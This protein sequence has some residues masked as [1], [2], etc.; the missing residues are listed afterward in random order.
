MRVLILGGTRNLGHDLVLHLLASGHAVSVLN[1]GRT[2]DTLPATVDR[3]RADRS[4]PGELREA[5]GRRRW[6]VVVD[7]TLYNGPDAE[8]AIELFSGRVE[9]YLFISTGQVYLVRT[10]APRPARE[11]DYAGPVLAEPV[12]GSRDH[13]NWV[14]GVEKRAAEDA[15]A[16]AGKESEF[17]VTALRLPMVNSRRDHYGRLHGYILR[18]QDGG[19]ILVPDGPGLSLRH[20]YGDDV[21]RVIGLLLESGTGKGEAFNLAQDE[22]V[23]LEEFLG[24]VSQAIPG[25][26]GR[27]RLTRAPLARL[28]E[29]HLFP[30]CSPFSD[31]WMSALDNRK[32]KAALGF[33]Y[34][35]LAVYLPQLVRHYLDTRPAAPAGYEQRPQELEL[36]EAGRP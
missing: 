8:A 26:R 23:S 11:E 16:R 30:A 15:L 5:V 31:T 4:A 12:A 14:Y 3:L 33:N 29:R 28:E 10:A 1:R 21:V 22:T 32:S 6:D 13:A 17:P 35:P 34:T 18:L 24:L 2:P 9:H 7:L 20:V 19:P 36:A 25:Q 27:L